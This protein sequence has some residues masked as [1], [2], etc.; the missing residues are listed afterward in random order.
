MTEQLSFPIA[1]G[2]GLLSFLS[3]CIL[4]LVP[5]YL[6]IL[7][8]AQIYENEVNRI[9]LPLFFHSLSFVLGFSVVFTALGVLAGLTGLYVD[10]I[11]L[12]KIAGTQNQTGGAIQ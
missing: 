11:L 4:P 5:V 8:G 9:N 3:P 7:G 2:A 10:P 1:F 12:N 6:G